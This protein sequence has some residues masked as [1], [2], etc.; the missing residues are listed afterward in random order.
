MLVNLPTPGSLVEGFTRRIPHHGAEDAVVRRA[1]LRLAHQ[2]E[3]VG[4]LEGDRGA[5]HELIG[6]INGAGSGR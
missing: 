5:E 3:R 2:R 6:E 1:L 4:P